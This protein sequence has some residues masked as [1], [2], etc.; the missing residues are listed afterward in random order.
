MEEAVSFVLGRHSQGPEGPLS[1]HSPTCECQWEN[2]RFPSGMLKVLV[3]VPQSCRL[4]VVA[5]QG[6]I[7]AR[8]TGKYD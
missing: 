7:P 1:A 3:R 2:G 4:Q 6:T 8:L 5:Q